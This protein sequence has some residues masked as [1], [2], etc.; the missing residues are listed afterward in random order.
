MSRAALD[1]EPSEDGQGGLRRLILS[2][3]AGHCK[4][5]PE[6]AHVLTALGSAV[7][8]A[9]SGQGLRTQPLPQDR[10]QAIRARL[11]QGLG[12]ACQ[13]LGAEFAG[14]VAA[15]VRLGAVTLLPRTPAV[16]DRGEMGPAA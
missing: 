13:D 10:P 2:V 15:G 14:V 5:S 11:L 16:L 4:S 3:A 1:G 7:D 9:L 8:E 6:P 12:R